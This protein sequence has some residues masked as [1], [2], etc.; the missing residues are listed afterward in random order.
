V[1]QVLGSE[2]FPHLGITATV[3]E[4]ALFLGHMLFKLIM[5]VTG[6]R[7]ED[8][9]DNCGNKRVETSGIL[10]TELF[11]TL[12]K[13]YTKTLTEQLKSRQ[14]ILQQVQKNTSITTGMK[15]SMSSSNWGVPK[16]SYVR[17]G[18]SQVLS[19]LSYQGFLSHLRRLGIHV[20]KSDK[21]SK[22]RQI[23]ESQFGYICPAETPEGQPVG[24]VLSLTLLARITKKVPTV[25]IKE[26]MEN[27][28]NII[29]VN[30]LELEECKEHTKVFLNGSLIGYTEDF[31]EMLIEVKNYRDSDLLDENVSIFYE[32]IDDEIHILSDEGRILRPLF[33]IEQGELIIEESC[34]LDWDKL[35]RN[36]KIVYIDVA[37]SQTCNIAMFPDDITADHH[38]CEIDPSMQLGVCASCIPF[39]DHNQS[40]R[41]CYQSSMGKQAM[42]IP[43][44]SHT[45]RA[46]TLLHVMAYPQKSLVTTRA[47]TYMGM[48]EMP[49]GINAIVAILTYGG[50]NQEDSILMNKNSIERGL[51]VA[52][53]YKTITGESKKSRNN[54]NS[55]SIEY[56]QP[57]IQRKE[58]NYSYLDK[59]TGIINPRMTIT[60][61]GHDGKD[62]TY[63]P[64]VR[65]K[66][67]DVIIGKVI[68]E[69]SK[70]G[71]EIKKDYSYT[72]KQGEE[73]IVDRVITSETPGGYT[74]V[75]VVI[76][77]ERIPE[78]G[79]K[80]AS[81]LAQKGTIG[82][83]ISQEDM[84]FNSQG[85]TPDIVINPHC[86]PSR[87][88][89]G[90]LLEN[91]LSKSCTQSGREGDATPFGSSSV[92]IAPKLCEELKSHGFEGTGKER[93]YN[94]MTGEMI[95]ASIF[96][97]PTYYQRLKHMASDK[98]H[99]RAQGKRTIMHHQPL[100][101]RSKD[102]GLRYGEMERDCMLA[103]GASA[104]TKDRL[105][106]VS[107]PY[108][109]VICNVCGQM[110]STPQQCV[111]CN[112]DKVTNVNIPYAAKQ[113]LHSLHTMGLKTVITA[114]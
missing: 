51:F 24:T 65:V 12:F 1:E 46:D 25:V 80:F 103:H 29:D 62:Y 53:T 10:L 11:R 70:N 7:E 41:N 5:T 81:R 71:V 8:H 44:S 37:E 72:I 42:G 75:K 100:E 91:V 88:T 18:V 69:G 83:I 92:G 17:T 68:T 20:G 108:S 97:G 60:K 15:H 85:M 82:Q 2:L 38:Y 61:K 67:G 3:K 40:P 76:R 14:D 30:E 54:Y 57:D 48:S 90:Q 58:W 6:L 47:A 22:L 63:H 32:D 34:G 96:M 26:I 77:T 50:G 66:K 13:R 43:V 78:I 74:L 106:D 107:D 93:L 21:N 98:I 64:E 109:V 79:D 55:E 23:H 111:T 101:G 99:A 94:G 45:I 105:F 49:S 114:T 52:Y 102:G 16:N 73:G 59:N 36:R 89:I 104:F 27:S 112:N 31:E 28:E 113:L 87:M 35:H 9:K 4:K 33:P 19:R 86:M 56:P 84:P 39:P 110:T 95:N